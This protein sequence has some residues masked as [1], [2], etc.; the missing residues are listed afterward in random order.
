MIQSLEYIWVRRC[1][2]VSCW[3]SK[4]E[5]TSINDNSHNPNQKWQNETQL[6]LHCSL[7]KA[8]QNVQQ[9]V[10][11]NYY[12]LWVFICSITYTACKAHVPCHIAI[13]GLSG[14]LIKQQDFQ[15]NVIENKM[16]TF[17][18]PKILVSNISYKKNSGRHYNKRTKV[19]T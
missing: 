14:C 10:S 12:I 9:F 16:F 8:G 6:L 19:L 11:N 15:K 5:N 4:Q 18:F 2:W 1:T 17:I 13:R 3:D 7:Y